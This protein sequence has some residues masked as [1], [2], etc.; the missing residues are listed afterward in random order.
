MPP[1]KNLIG[2]KFG[3][4]SPIQFCYLNKKHYAVWLC[5]CDCG[6]TKEVMSTSLIHGNTQSCGCLYG[7]R[8]IA[9]GKQNKVHG[10]ARTGLR[11]R[12]YKTW[13]SMKMRC[14]NPKDPAFERYGGR[15]IK[16]C[17]RWMD[18]E[19][20]LEDMGERPAGLTLERIDNEGNYEPGNC[21][22]ATR[23]E[24]ANN[25]RRRSL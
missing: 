14:L 13:V 23:K 20:F 25:R 1:I 17:N 21:K 15:G 4:L 12:P 6:K 10:H 22:W 9:N 24:Q 18:F 7:E 8:M 5:L 11:S 16:V 3:R 19:N 2:Q